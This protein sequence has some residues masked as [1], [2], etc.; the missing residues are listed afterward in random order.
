MENCRFALLPFDEQKHQ[1]GSLHSFIYSWKTSFGFASSLLFFFFISLLLL[2]MEINWCSRDKQPQKRL[3]FDHTIMNG[4]RTTRDE[5]INFD[6]ETEIKKNTKL[7]C[8]SVQIIM[9]IFRVIQRSA[10][11]C[12]V[13]GWS[14]RASV[15]EATHA[16]LM[17]NG[18]DDDYDNHTYPLCILRIVHGIYYIYI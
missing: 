6:F 5:F 12:G 1:P 8:F 9:S 7:S 18:V 14:H 2:E 16:Y 3:S 15:F 10:R 13:I 11:V 17:S 4:D